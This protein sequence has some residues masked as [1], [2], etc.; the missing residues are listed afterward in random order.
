MGPILNSSW[1]KIGYKYIDGTFFPSFYIMLTRC[2]CYR[3]SAASN[4]SAAGNLC[5]ILMSPGASS[6]GTGA[7]TSSVDR[8]I[9]RQVSIT[10][11]RS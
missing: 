2:H 8:M 1:N 3:M 4:I 7:I 6:P 11:M 10:L 5:Q 9:Q